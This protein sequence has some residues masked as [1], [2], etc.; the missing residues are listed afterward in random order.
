MFNFGSQPASVS[1][2]QVQTTSTNV[3]LGG[4][5]SASTT[6]ASIGLSGSVAGS[7]LSDDKTIMTPGSTPLLPEFVQLV[8]NFKQVV[9]SNR[10]TLDALDNEDM[11]EA[12]QK[13]QQLIAATA[14]RV[15]KIECEVKA[16]SMDTAA[17]KEHSRH[18]LKSLQCLKIPADLTSYS[19]NCGHLINF[20]WTYALLSEQ[21]LNACM[22]QI[23]QY[24]QLFCTEG[25]SVGTLKDV[26]LH[27][28]RI[29]DVFKIAHRDLSDVHD[30]IEILKERFIL[31]R[32]R[33]F[34]DRTDYFNVPST[35]PSAAHD[36]S[37]SAQRKLEGP[38]PFGPNS[39]ATL[40]EIAKALARNSQGNILM[41]GHPIACPTM[42][43]SLPQTAASFSQFPA[44]SSASTAP[45]FSNTSI[46][47]TSASKPLFQQ[48]PQNQTSLFNTTTPAIGVVKPFGK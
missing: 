14:S 29:D 12:V 8:D 3:G 5:S 20:L 24:E 39:V 23:Q 17:M 33:V 1:A 9:T 42:T 45:T 25:A 4:S 6:T 21:K 43:S 41:Q 32:Q 2:P 15:E 46:F 36:R 10:N 40:I 47:N 22:Q 48:G 37:L 19:F 31:Y 35:V 38:S 30:Q 7:S 28:K 13:V 34:N 18:N 27:L 44:F 26:L 16:L 11:A